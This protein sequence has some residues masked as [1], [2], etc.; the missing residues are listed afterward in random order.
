LH[1]KAAAEGMR[2]GLGGKAV[3]RI[4]VKGREKELNGDEVKQS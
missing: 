4:R 2:Q 3:R 1:V